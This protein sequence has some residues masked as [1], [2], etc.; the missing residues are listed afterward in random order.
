MKMFQTSAK[1]A[2]SGNVL[3]F[4][5]GNFDAKVKELGKTL[6][7]LKKEST[8]AKKTVE[9]IPAAFDKSVPQT[10]SF[11]NKIQ[12]LG[13]TIFGIINTVSLLKSTIGN[14]VAATESAEIANAKLVNGLKNVG[15]G[16]GALQKLNKQATIFRNKLIK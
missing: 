2:L 14:L 9:D 13:Q 7:E 1:D 4:N 3:T 15:E 6:D 5:A 12:D 8:E 16:Y 10:I 11:K